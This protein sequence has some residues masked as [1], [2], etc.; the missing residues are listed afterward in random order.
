VF[1]GCQKLI[2]LPPICQDKELQPIQLGC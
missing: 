2:A 1:R